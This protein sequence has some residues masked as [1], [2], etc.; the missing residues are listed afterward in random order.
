MDE[1]WGLGGFERE[2][3]ALVAEGR[4]RGWPVRILK[5]LT[6]MN[7]SGLVVPQLLAEPGFDAGRDL[8]VLVD[9]FAIPLGQF[10]LRARGSAGGHGGLESI[11]QALGSQAYARLRIG[12][13]P[14]PAEESGA[15]FS[16][17][18]FSKEELDRLADLQPVLCDAVDC[19]LAEGIETAMNRFNRLGR[20]VERD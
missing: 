1:Q 17:G 8:L 14:R 16:L 13:G 15:E 9:D 18:R 5:P 20:G 19:W 2:G 7:R 11:E 3:I 12:I 6:Y 10:R 4:R